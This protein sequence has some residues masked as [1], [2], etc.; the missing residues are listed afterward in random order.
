MF[1]FVGI[2]G[3][4]ILIVILLVIYGPRRVPQ[5]TRA[6]RKGGREFKNSITGKHEPL[7][8]LPPAAVE[9]SETAAA[10]KR[11]TVV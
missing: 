1:A 8:E 9:S 10:R 4:V 7:G 2:P 11:D 6:I 3:L 5:T